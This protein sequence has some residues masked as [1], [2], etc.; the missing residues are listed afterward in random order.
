MAAEFIVVPAGDELRSENVKVEEFTVVPVGDELRSE[1][2]K[3][4]QAALQHF[5]FCSEKT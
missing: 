2:M 3:V 1:N 4:L 5:S